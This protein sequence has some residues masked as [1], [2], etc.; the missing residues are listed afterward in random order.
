MRT[1]LVSPF[2]DT[3][4]P[5]IRILSNCLRREG[6]STSIV[7]MCSEFHESYPEKAVKDLAEICKDADL[8]GFSMMSN[9]YDNIRQMIAAIKKH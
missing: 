6:H 1:V 2:P 7:F 9:F 4:A 8:V 3:W 5:G